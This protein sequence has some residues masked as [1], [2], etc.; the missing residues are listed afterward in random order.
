MSNITIGTCVTP[1]VVLQRHDTEKEERA[2]GAS[3]KNG[4]GGVRIKRHTDLFS[5]P[6]PLAQLGSFKFPLL[7]IVM[8]E[9]TF[10]KLLV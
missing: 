3:R 9:E 2:K 10:P 7:L 4:A 1:C 8:A 6:L 5:N